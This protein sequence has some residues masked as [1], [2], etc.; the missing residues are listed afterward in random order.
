MEPKI[1]ASRVVY[2]PPEPK[3]PKP[4]EPKPVLPPPVQPALPP[5][6]LTS[7][8]GPHSVHSVPR[9]SKRGQK[10][11]S[12][13]APPLPPVKLTKTRQ[14]PE[15][16]SIMSQALSALQS[17]SE[18][19]F[20]RGPTKVTYTPQEHAAAQREHA[21]KFMKNKSRAGRDIAPLEG[22]ENINW[23]LRLA[24]KTDLKLFCKTYL[25][26]V[27]SRNWSQDQIRCA[28][29]MESV[30]I[31]GG[32]FCLAQPRAGGKTALCRGGITWGSA[33][34]HRKFM[35]FIGSTQPKAQQT[36]HFIKTYWYRSE[37]LRRDFPEI[38]Y[39]IHK[40][41]NR[42]HLASGQTF[43]GEPT[44]GEWG[45][46]SIRF[47]SLLLPKEI[48]EVYLQHDPSCVTY[49]PEYDRWLP[50]QAGLLIS[51]AGIDGSIR[52]EADV[53]PILLD[54]PRPD[55]VLLD[56]VQK[57]AKADS[58]TSCEK[59]VRLIDGAV[60][61]LAGPGERIA[62]L[63]PCTV[64]REG[65]VSDTYLDVMQKPDWNGERCRMVIQWPPG[66]TDFEIGLET[67]AGKCWNNYAGLR[68]K[69]LLQYQDIR[70]ATEYYAANRDIMDDGYIVSW[71]E[72]FNT[73]GKNV[74]LSAQQN[75]MELRLISPK[76]FV[77]EYQNIGR[78][79]LDEGEMLITAS[80]L[81]NKTIGLKWLEVPADTEI[82]TCFVDVQNEG[83]FWQAFSSNLD[84]TGHIPAW[85]VHPKIDT[86]HWSRD[87]LDSWSLLTN[88]F[89]AKHPNLR[90]EATHTSRGYIRA[91]FEAK[92][93][94]GLEE[95]IKYLLSLKFTRLGGGGRVMKIQKIGIDTR[96]GNASEVIKRFIRE[97]GLV[98]EI[99]PYMGQAMPPT[100]TQL[101]EYQ[102]TDGWLFEHQKHPNV[103]EPMWV[104]RPGKLT[105]D[106]YMM[107][108]VSRGKD[109]L[110]QR[111]ASPKGAMGSI[112][113]PALQAEVL[114]LLCHQICDSEFPEVVMSRGRVKNVW[115]ERDPSVWDNDMLDCAVGNM[116]LASYLGASIKTSDELAR[117]VKRKLS[118]QY[119]EKRKRLKR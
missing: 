29:K 7:K 74:E 41:E 5:K 91:P 13:L 92:I 96:Y 71:K 6:V 2:V 99:I 35:F 106:Y 32:M 38:G 111:L 50:I 31:D 94:F 46:E 115:M 73:K 72:R 28:D 84:F 89:F 56:D 47:P 9:S 86:H 76:T 37:L 18:P 88:K 48:A 75:A 97:S 39:A 105:G 67:P 40:F 1:V 27:F 19:T 116:M 108:D 87:Q 78:K 55:L 80:Q 60:S 4:P 98:N 93:Y 110:F 3:P 119:A 49:I 79:L 103:K 118:Q 104:V 14:A 58:P 23:D 81:M 62:A 82:L 8:R 15:G 20:G 54:Q 83:F 102:L 90:K 36:L 26:N 10:A 34:G 101:E 65:D 53:H 107:A 117:P 51:T 24:C 77:S 12:P 66:I 114:E 52:G 33:Y 70:L 61:G 113:I 57:D 30:F 85:G 69:S 22:V 25:P 17:V 100:H 45:G 42:F 112:T 63:M 21:A 109:F 95:V 11:K 68:R 44:H 16:P 59:L 43:D 64:I